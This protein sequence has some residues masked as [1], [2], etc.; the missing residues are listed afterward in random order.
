MLAA[1]AVAQDEPNSLV[2]AALK[3]QGLKQAPAPTDETARLMAQI[4]G[5]AKAKKTAAAPTGGDGAAAN[6]DAAR[7]RGSRSS[8]R[9]DGLVV[10]AVAPRPRRGESAGVAAT[11]QL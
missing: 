3:R 7:R 6:G 1:R 9:R 8:L 5:E 11:P 10:V 4:H 2:A